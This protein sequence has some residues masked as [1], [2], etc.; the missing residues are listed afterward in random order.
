MRHNLDLPEFYGSITVSVD[1]VSNKVF[2]C[3]IF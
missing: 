1:N 2:G 3:H